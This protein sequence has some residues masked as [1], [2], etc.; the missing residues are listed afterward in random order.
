[1]DSG[2]FA[3]CNL[4]TAWCI[5]LLVYPICVELE[6]TLFPCTT[7]CLRFIHV[8]G[9]LPSLCQWRTSN[10]NAHLLLLHRQERYLAV[11]LFTRNIP[12]IY[13]VCD[14][15]AYHSWS[16]EPRPT[17]HWQSKQLRVCLQVHTINMGDNA[18]LNNIL[19]VHFST[20]DFNTLA[21]A[22][23]P[24]VE[25]DHFFEVQHI[26]NII[27]P[28]IG[29]NWYT[30]PIGQ[31]LDLSSFVNEH[32]NM[33]QITRADNQQKK[34]IALAQYPNNPFIA[35]Y[36]NRQLLGGGTVR[37][38]VRALAQAMRARNTPHSQLTRHV[39]TQLCTLMG[40]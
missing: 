21:P 18:L 9:V 17:V 34:A 35:A 16:E 4:P 20:S 26:V 6:A 33:F 25:I 5:G 29:S 19:R 37:D 30:L 3:N 31:F 1:M 27:I 11:L 38:S 32:R 7:Y 40:W 36:L 10:P 14:I 22:A 24:P 2:V 8:W 23:Q 12:L 13:P 15:M 28:V 39:G